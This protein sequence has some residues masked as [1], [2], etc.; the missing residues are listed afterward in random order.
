MLGLKLDESLEECLKREILEETG[1][2]IFSYERFDIFS[3]PSR[4]VSYPDGNKL[5]IVTIAFIVKDFEVGGL[6]LSD[7]SLDT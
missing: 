1:M 6:I 2:E 5:R 3:D 7:E 4:I